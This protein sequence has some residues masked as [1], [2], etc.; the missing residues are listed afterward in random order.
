MFPVFP[1]FQ[2]ISQLAIDCVVF[3]TSTLIWPVYRVPGGV[4][5]FTTLLS[6]E[7][8]WIFNFMFYSLYTAC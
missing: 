7:L 4:E 6:L 3:S 8:S 1:Y 5:H 2:A